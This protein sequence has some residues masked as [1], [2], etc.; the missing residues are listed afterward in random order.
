M[1][2]LRSLACLT[3][4]IAAA[5]LVSAQTIQINRDNKTIAIS[6]T[7]E[8]TATADIAAITI[9]FEI[10]GPDALTV[11]AD[12]GKLSQAI[13]EALHEAGVEDKAIES[14]AQGV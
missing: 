8:A 4:G 11:S 1:R 13:L 7:D 2:I 6:S 3:I 12:G 5:G 14:S 9:G 10:F